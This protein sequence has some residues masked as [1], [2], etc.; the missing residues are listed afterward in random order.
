MN[1]INS[2]LNSINNDINDVLNGIYYREFKKE[3]LTVEADRKFAKELSSGQLD[4]EIKEEI[5]KESNW[6]EQEKSF[7]DMI[8]EKLKSSEV[9][10]TETYEDLAYHKIWIT[11]DKR[12]IKVSDM[13]TKHIAATLRLLKTKPDH[14]LNFFTKWSRIFKYELDKRFTDTIVI[15][16]DEEL[17]N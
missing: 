16:Q 6:N 14:Y 11:S 17:E 7:M 1:E 5:K 12:L 2:I 15:E 9:L 10:D 4:V 3:K 8:S 13:G